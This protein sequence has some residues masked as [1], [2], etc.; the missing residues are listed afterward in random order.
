MVSCKEIVKDETKSKRL[1]LLV[2]PSVLEQIKAVADRKY[3]SVNEAFNQAALEY[4][5]NNKME[6]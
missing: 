1:N 2:Y 4:I 6:D 3:I 5:A